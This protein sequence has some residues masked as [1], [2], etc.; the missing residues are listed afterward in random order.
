MTPHV[1]RDVRDQD[2]N[3]VDTYE[4]EVWTTAM[5]RPT[6]ALMRDAMRGVVD[7]GTASRARRPR[8]RR[9]RQDGHRPARHRAGPL[10]RV[11]HRLRRVPTVASRPSRSR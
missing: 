4:P 10:P 11:D 8:L 7:S 9:R 1:L 6:A 3:V 5:D 2:G